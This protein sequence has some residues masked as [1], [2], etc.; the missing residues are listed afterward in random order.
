M[1]HERMQRRRRKKKKSGAEAH[2]LEKPQV[3]RVLIEVEDGSVAVDLPSLGTQHVFILIVSC[4]HC[5]GIFGRRYTATY[6]SMIHYAEQNN[7]PLVGEWVGKNVTYTHN[8]IL[9]NLKW[10]EI[11]THATT[12]MKLQAAV[13]V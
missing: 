10:K 3:L 1:E 6:G 2:G 7:C 8:R 5:W 4:F 12:W 11:L 13:C 9:F